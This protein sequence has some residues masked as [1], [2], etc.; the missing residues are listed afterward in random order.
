MSGVPWLGPEKI[1][2]ALYDRLCQAVTAEEVTAAYLEWRERT[3]F[4][5]QPPTTGADEASI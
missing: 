5:A 3:E 4:G 2:Q 1:D